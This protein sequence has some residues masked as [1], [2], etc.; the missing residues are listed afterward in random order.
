MITGMGAVTALGLGADRLWGAVKNGISGIS[1][2][3]RMDVTGLST[4]IAAEIKAFDAGCF[5]EK[6]ES[7]RMDRFTQYAVAAAQMAVDQARLHIA[8]GERAGVIVGSGIGGLETL[9]NQ[10]NV[11]LEK[12]PGRVSPFMVPMMLP[13][14]AAGML[15]IRFG[16]KGFVECVV[17]ACASSTNAI[18]DACRIIRQNMADVMIAGGA[19]A[20]ITRLAMAGFNANKAMST[21][22]DAASASRPFDRNRDGFVMGEGAGILILEELNH[23]VARGADIIAEVTGYGCTNDAYHMTAVAP[24]GA[25]GAACMCLALAD[26][27]ISPGEIQYINAHGTSTLLNDKSET[28]AIKAVFGNHAYQLAVS[29][30]KSMTGHLFGA[31]GAVEAIITAAAIKDGF[32]P[33]TINY[34]QPDPECDLNYIPNVGKPAVIDQAL[35]NSF[36]FGGHNASL[37]LKAF[38]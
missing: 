28:E 22:P 18:G 23:A 38:R 14:M 24:A 27:G 32:L 2:I 13:N 25:G 8:N 3:E 10:H 31:A 36:G 12:G 7:K 4:Q 35:S 11:L 30:T 5:I 21:N 16:I 19:E 1:Q 6:K 37:V 29:S 26:A 9:E 33:P 17:T 15:A 34:Q 20:P